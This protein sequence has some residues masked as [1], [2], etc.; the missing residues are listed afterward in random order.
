LAEII[1]LNQFSRNSYRDY[2]KAF[3]YDNLA[4]ALA[5]TAVAA[6]ADHELDI[7]QGAFLYMPYMH[8]ESL[9]IHEVAV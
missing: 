7:E 3:S 6:N 4:F 2:P 8:S 9:M 5:Q 1:V